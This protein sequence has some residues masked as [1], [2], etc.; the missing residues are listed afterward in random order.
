MFKLDKNTHMMVLFTFSLIFIVVYLYYTITD[1]R[2]M[3]KEVKRLS[4]EL[5]KLQKEPPVQIKP[6]ITPTPAAASAPINPVPIVECKQVEPGADINIH[7][8]DESVLTDEIRETLECTDDD[9]D[10]DLQ[11]IINS[12]DKQIAGE[13]ADVVADV[14]AG[15]VAEVVAGEA[16]VV[17]RAVVDEAVVDEAVAIDEADILLMKYDDLKELCKKRNLSQKGAKDV[18]IKRLLES[19]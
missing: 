9:E 13:V 18:L 5:L 3:Q 17:A 8:D 16:A 1:V 10:I 14:V 19:K 4:D 2:K 11:N 12:A 15:E 7:E 6:V